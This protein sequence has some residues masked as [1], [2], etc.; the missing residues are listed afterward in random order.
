ML[1]SNKTLDDRCF[2]MITHSPFKS[3]FWLWC[4]SWLCCLKTEIFSKI[5][6]QLWSQYFLPSKSSL[7]HSQVLGLKI[8]HASTKFVSWMRSWS[9]FLLGDISYSAPWGLMKW[10]FDQCFLLNGNI[11]ETKH[12]FYKFLHKTGSKRCFY[13]CSVFKYHPNL[14]IIGIIIIKKY[15]EIT[16]LHF[17][18]ALVAKMK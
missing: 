12:T 10:E 9:N 7:P 11:W 5:I 6:F 18:K 14:F 8:S 4:F 15:S 13:F 2:W 3:N 17:L 16:W 1:S